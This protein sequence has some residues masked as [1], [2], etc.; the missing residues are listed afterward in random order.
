MNKEELV[1]SLVAALGRNNVIDAP[2]QL[3]VYECDGL[4]IDRN[5]PHAVVFPTTTEEVAAVVRVLNLAQIPFVARGAGTGLSGGSLPPDGGVMIVLTKM[6]KIVE[7]DFRN[8]RALVEAGVVNL[9]LSTEVGRKGYHFVPDPSS[10]YAC[11]I[12]GNIAENSGGPHTL[13]Y[14]VTTNHTLGV[15]VVMPDG[16]ITWFGGK[17]DDALGYDLRGVLIGSEGMLGIVTRAWVKLTRLPQAWRTF[18]VVFDTLDDASRA[19][20]GVIARGIVP[21]AMEMLDKVV[22][23]AIEEAYHFGFPLEAEAVLIIELEGH[24]AGLNTQAE[25]VVVVC[26][27]NGA[28]DVRTAEDEKKRALLWMSRKR[29]FGA[30]GRLSPSYYVQDGV[31]PRT[32][33]PDIMRVIQATAKKYEL[34]IGNVFHAGDG[35]IH[36]CIAYDDRDEDQTRRTVE[37]SNEILQACVN[38]GGSIT[39]EHGIGYE[40]VDLMPL[41]FEKQDIQAMEMVK[42]IF[43]ANHLSNPGK[44][45]PINRS[46]I[47]CGTVELKYT[48]RKAALL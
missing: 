36:P 21:S 41:I 6:D 18:L 40:K 43:D 9:H 13:K 12:G 2:D 38:L 46:C 10:Q 15:E 26:K 33:I 17:S 48:N 11:T 7:V 28:T 39:G 30:M 23:G 4:T 47:G 8:Q 32:K 19:V 14:G 31:V 44:M 3:I 22:I 42:D 45:F 5:S 35:N 24:E 37:A 25:D 1:G 34:L 29:A 27:E 16:Q 20:S